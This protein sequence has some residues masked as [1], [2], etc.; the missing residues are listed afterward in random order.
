M[1]DCGVEICSTTEHNDFI[2]KLLERGSYNLIKIV[3][4][5]SSSKSN[6]ILLAITCWL[7]PKLS[8]K[9]TKYSA[10]S[11]Y[12]INYKLELINSSLLIWVLSNL[13]SVL[14]E[15]ISLI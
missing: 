7:L 15:L 6:S 4:F 11:L 1:Y 3:G 5:N 10:S 12:D 13:I 2:L 9:S 8:K 14:S